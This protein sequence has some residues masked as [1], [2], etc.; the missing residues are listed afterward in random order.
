MAKGKWTDPLYPYTL[1]K[2]KIVVNVTRSCPNFK[3]PAPGIPDVAAEL[4]KTGKMRV[5]DFGAGKLRNAQYLLNLKAGFTVYAVEYPGCFGTPAGAT[6]KAE[7]Q[8]SKGFFF[9]EFPDQFLGASFTVDAVLLVNV[10]NVV[11]DPSDRRLIMSECTKRLKAGGWFLWMSQYGEPH[12]KPGVT[13]RLKAPDGGWFYNLHAAHQTYNREFTIPEIK[14]FF[15]KKHYREIRKV[16]AA[17]HR[18]FIF[19]RL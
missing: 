10:A 7:A 17:H 15:P 8:K 1:P 5:L 16:S 6:R 13:K 9:L 12:Y 3:T 11:P 2:R 18:A 14:A 4:K 19:E